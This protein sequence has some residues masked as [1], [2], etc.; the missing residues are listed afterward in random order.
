M[1]EHSKHSIEILILE[2]VDYSIWLLIQATTQIEPS[3]IQ[4]LASYSGL[5]FSQAI[6]RPY[7]K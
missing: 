3:L 1:G 2:F 7:H 5:P 4:K 6:H